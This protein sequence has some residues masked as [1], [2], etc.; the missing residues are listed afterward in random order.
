[1][2]ESGNLMV[3]GRCVQP[4]FGGR[5]RDSDHADPPPPGTIAKIRSA[6]RRNPL[7]TIG[8]FSVLVF[9]IFAIFA[10]FIAPFD[11][12]QINLPQR[13]SPPS[14]MHWF[15]TDELGRDILSRVIFGA[16]LS[17]FVSISVVAG[18]LGIGLIVGAIAGFYGGRIDRFVNVFLMNAF[19]SFPGILLAIAFVAFVGPGIMNLVLAL[20]IGGWVGYARL[21]RAQVLAV[22]EREFVEAAQAPGAS[23]L[24]LIVRHILPN[25]IQPVLVQGAIG[26]AGAVLAEAT[27]SFLGLGVPPPAASWG[28]MLNDARSHL[29]DA[30]H[31]VLFPA[32]AVMLAVLSFN[33][34]GDAL[35]DFLDPRSRIEAGL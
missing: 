21:V 30:P 15:G 11:P 1:M 16:R 23:D 26:M 24:R 10:P 29:F 25:I 6:A 3:E 4:G 8:I 20:A 12:A 34:I 7:A 14:A 19:L 18:S 32:A 13:L 35:R 9:V 17:M 2:S 28:S 22:R 27:M 31:L 5:M 33:F